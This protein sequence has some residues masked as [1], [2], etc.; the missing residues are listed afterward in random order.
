M[1]KVKVF[2]KE[3]AWIVDPKIKAFAEKLIECAP[4][5]FF[6]VAASS[7]GKYHSSYSLGPGGLVRHTKSATAILHELT[8]NLE[9]FNKYSQDQKDMMLVAIMAHDFFKHGLAAQAGKYTVAE[10]PVVCAD[11]IR[12]NDKVC[13]L[14]EREQIEFIAGCVASHMGQF[15][16]DYKSKKQ[17]LPKPQTGPQNLVHLADYLASRKFLTFEFGDEYYRPESEQCEEPVHT[18]DGLVSAKAQIVERCKD[19]IAA[20]VDN[21]QIYAV[22]AEKNGGNR[23]PNSISD[24]TT[25]G[26]VLKALEGIGVSH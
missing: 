1:N 10:H 26:E 2:E 24:M 7:T 6:E 25:I 18:N 15:C 11:F 16:F 3:L 12:Y 21:K 5:Y 9:M 14:L 8:S 17:I 13:N 4:D 20:G 22:I 23:N 19:L